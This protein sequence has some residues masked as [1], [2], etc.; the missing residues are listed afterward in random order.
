MRC[1]MGRRDETASC[2]PLYNVPE[3]CPQKAL[4]AASTMTAE[5]HNLVYQLLP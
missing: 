1:S 5:R 4:K 3:A 2:I